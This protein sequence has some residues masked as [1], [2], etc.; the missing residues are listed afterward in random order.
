MPSAY[1]LQMY[2][3]HPQKLALEP[4]SPPTLVSFGTLSLGAFPFLSDFT[5]SFFKHCIFKELYSFSLIRRQRNVGHLSITKQGESQHLIDILKG[6]RDFLT[7]YKE[8]V[9]GRIPSVQERKE[10]FTI[11]ADTQAR[12]HQYSVHKVHSLQDIHK[13]KV[14]Q[15]SSTPTSLAFANRGVRFKNHINGRSKIPSTSVKSRD[16]LQFHIRSQ[17]IIRISTCCVGR[18]YRARNRLPIKTF[19]EQV[20]FKEGGGG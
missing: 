13:R 18:I 4:L 15:Q 3:I 10:A 7:P 11:L 17:N 1:S 16:M 2:L 9:G 19:I 5:T 20:V 14:Y 6:R 12:K 8:G